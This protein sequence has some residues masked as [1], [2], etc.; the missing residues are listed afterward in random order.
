MEVRYLIRGLQHFPQRGSIAV[1]R[2][3]IFE[4][5]VECYSAPQRSLSPESGFLH[6][7]KGRKSPRP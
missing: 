7:E 2:Q 4:S 6:P 3:P 5:F 1:E